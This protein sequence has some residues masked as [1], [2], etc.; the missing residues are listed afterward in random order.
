MAA[1]NKRLLISESRGDSNQCTPCNGKPDQ[2][3]TYASHTSP[4]T[5]TVRFLRS[6]PVRGNLSQA[7]NSVGQTLLLPRK[8]ASD[9][10]PSPAEWSI[11]PPPSLSPNTVIEAVMK[12]KHL[13][14]ACY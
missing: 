14:T 9:I 2:H 11:G 6:I 12:A 1:T 8:R 4:R 7:T 13:L 3:D 5:P 10:T